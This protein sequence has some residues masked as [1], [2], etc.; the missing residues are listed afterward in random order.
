MR[1]N[2]RPFRRTHNNTLNV[3][4]KHNALND[5]F[6]KQK[7]IFQSMTPDQKLKIALSLY[8]SARQLKAAGL[9]AQ[10]PDWS[11]EKVQNRLREIFLYART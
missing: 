2:R 1:G 8:Y 3:Q 10:N 11:E 4:Y 5:M 7:H 9:R 6:K